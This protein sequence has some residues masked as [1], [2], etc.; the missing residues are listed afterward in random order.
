MRTVSPIAFLVPILL[1]LV[2]WVVST[3]LAPVDR[4]RQQVA[5]RH[6]D[7][8]D[9]VSEDE[10]PDEV[11]PLV[12]EL[13]LLFSRVHQAFEAQRNFVSDAAHELRSPLAALK[14]QVEGLRR[15]QTVSS[16]DIAVQR[17]GSGVDRA[18]HLV[19]QLLNLARQQALGFNGIVKSEVELTC[20]TEAV[21][22]EMDARAEARKI[23]LTIVDS[24]PLRVSG[25]EDALRILVRNLLENSIKY[26]PPQGR[27]E[28]SVL[29]ASNTCI[30][31]V[32]DSGPGIPL[33]ERTRVLDRFYRMPN[34]DGSGSGLGLA[35][36]Q[37]IV[38]QH[39]ARM[40]FESSPQLGGLRVQIIFGQI[41]QKTFNAV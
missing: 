7:S 14:L 36:V 1:F 31:Q 18:T 28:V 37:T 34:A 20:L 10:V 41:S 30:L 11:R 4:V 23:R 6:A 26:S 15:A 38:D 33:S 29:E 5:S 9:Q 16:R 12:H 3:S 25:Q 22:L 35:I 39:E 2:W 8:L 27:V 21:I 17:L 13:N 32:D 24:K 19:E 40:Q